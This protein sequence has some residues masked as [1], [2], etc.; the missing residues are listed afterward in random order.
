M[1]LEKPT[2]SCKIEELPVIAG[3][4]SGSLTRDL[5]MMTNKYPAMDATY[6]TTY[7]GKIAAVDALINPVKET[8]ELKLLTDKLYKDV[9]KVRPMMLDLEGYVVR[10]VDMTVLPKDFGIS[11]V[12]KCIDNGDVEGLD[13]KL[14][15]VLQNITD[16]MS[17]LTAQGYTAAKK[18]A[19]ADLKKAIKDANIAQQA[20]VEARST[21]VNNNMGVLNDLHKMMK[22]LMDAGKRVMKE[23]DASKVDDY[24]F[25]KLKKKV[26]NEGGGGTPPVTPG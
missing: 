26:R 9:A 25:A 1:A 21:R 5:V 6:V 4:L 19:L 11:Q 23:N 22:D 8:K 13:M 17:K 20:I 7:N 12:R 3:Y 15:I 14:K 10:A 16:N 24:T 2:F 18:T